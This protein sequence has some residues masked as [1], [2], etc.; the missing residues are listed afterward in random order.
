[1][2]MSVVFYIG[3]VILTMNMGAKSEFVANVLIMSGLL[4]S[5]IPDILINAD[6]ADI[7]IKRH[8]RD[9]IEKMTVF[10]AVYFFNKSENTLI[11]LCVFLLC[12]VNAIDVF[13]LWK[14]MIRACITKAK[15]VELLKN[16]EEKNIEKLLEYLIGNSIN[17]AIFVNMQDYMLEIII[18]AVICI[19]VHFYLCEKIL[20]EIKKIRKIP[21]NKYRFILWGIHIIIMVICIMKY[22]MIC[23]VLEGIYGMIVIDVTMQNKT[24]IIKEK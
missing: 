6:I 1:M 14:Q 11:F 12:I 9:L 22:S 18:W 24:A 21:V 16:R 13:C 10:L 8:R 15:L 7:D 5:C 17:I 23:Y 3:I 20:K 19:G 4:V 2:G